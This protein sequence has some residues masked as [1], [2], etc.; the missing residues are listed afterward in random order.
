MQLKHFFK[1]GLLLLFFSSSA[2]SPDIIITN[3]KI[4]TS[5]AK[6]LYT[7]AIAIKGNRIIAR[8]N[9]SDIV[10]LAAAST[11]VI[12]VQGKTVVPGFNDAHYHHNPYTQGYH[13]V[14]PQDGSEPTWQQLKD[15][16]VSAVNKVPKGTFIYAEMGT[17]VGTDTSINRSV[18]DQLAPDHP[19]LIHAYW[20]HVA[21][22]NSAIMNALRLSNNL[23][24]IKG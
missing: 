8:G 6:Q 16:I 7:E 24:D 14:Y 12:D 2:Q 20:G 19:L 15:S 9:K 1:A 3:G 23:P 17:A 5:D 10:K 22:F 11:K 18:L 13:I 4:F 21:Y